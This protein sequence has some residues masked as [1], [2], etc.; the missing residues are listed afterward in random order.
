MRASRS[1][2]RCRPSISF[3][4]ICG[5]SF[6]PAISV[7]AFARITATGVRS[8]CDTFATKSRRTLSSRR[9]VV[10]SS[11]S[12]TRPAR[13]HV[14]AARINARG[15]FGSWTSA[16]ASSGRSISARSSGTRTN[17]SSG[18]PTSELCTPSMRRAASLSIS[19]RRSPSIAITPCV[20]PSATDASSV[21]SCA[22]A[23][24]LRCASS[25]SALI[26][27][28]SSRK[29][30]PSDAVEHPARRI[31]HDVLHRRRRRA[32]LA[33]RM[34]RDGHDRRRDHE[35]GATSTNVMRRPRRDRS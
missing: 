29:S 32:A 3:G 7:S 16:L 9:T 14:R 4:A 28:A 35:H 30:P 17:S 13:P 11:S 27:S 25:A 1:A 6:A 24:R 26:H 18:S 21:R 23:L 19:I 31:A 22:R 33:A 10:T 5:S 34:H 15:P 2:L 20:R 8:S 12:S